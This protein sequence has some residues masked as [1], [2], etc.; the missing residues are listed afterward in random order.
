[1]NT[2]FIFTLSFSTIFF[3]SL[4]RRLIQFH[5]RYRDLNLIL[6][7]KSVPEK[8]VDLNHMMRLSPSRDFLESCSREMY[9][10]DIEVIVIVVIKFPSF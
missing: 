7:T 9:Q 1:M 6:Q 4:P 10:T 8:S 2:Y 3:D 5:R